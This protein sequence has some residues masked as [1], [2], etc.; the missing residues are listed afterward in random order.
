MRGHWGIR[1]CCRHTVAADNQQ[2]SH[3]CSAQVLAPG[4]PEYKWLS[5][6][7]RERGSARAEQRFICSF[8]LEG[9][10][11]AVYCILKKGGKKVSCSKMKRVV[12]NLKSKGFKF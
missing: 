5:K 10:V 8:S 3:V 11:F 9:P 6:Q 12:F 4:L 7:A 1:E 2:E